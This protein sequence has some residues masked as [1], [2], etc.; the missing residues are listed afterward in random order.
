MS[1]ASCS[2]SWVTD[3]RSTYPL[4]HDATRLE[5]MRVLRAMGRVLVTVHAV[6]DT[7]APILRRV[8]FR[9]EFETVSYEQAPGP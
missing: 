1:G 4:F 9:D 7:S 2:A 3:P 8:A 5:R 6:D